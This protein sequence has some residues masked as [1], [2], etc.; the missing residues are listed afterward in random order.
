MT[1]MVHGLLGSIGTEASQ[2][3]RDLRWM[4]VDSNPQRSVHKDALQRAKEIRTC[5]LTEKCNIGQ[6]GICT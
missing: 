1:A 5:S 4:A 6:S 3:T 2:G